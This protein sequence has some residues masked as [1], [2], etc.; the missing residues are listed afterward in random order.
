MIT[1]LATAVLLVLAVAACGQQASGPGSAPAPAPAAGAGAGTGGFGVTERAF[2]ELSIATG[3]QAVR[4][5]DLGFQRAAGAPLRALAH[6]VAADRQAELAELR[7]LLDTERIAYANHHAGHD[8]P[9]MPTGAELETLAAS[10][11]GFDAVFVRLLR[12]H[13]EESTT[14]VRSALG[15]VTHEATRAVANRMEQGRAVALHRLAEVA[16]TG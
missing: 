13:L 7:G 9:G 4:L 12:A 6:D 2:V 10:G 1:R 8:M 14:V 3:E 5:L 11:N 16:G 15:S